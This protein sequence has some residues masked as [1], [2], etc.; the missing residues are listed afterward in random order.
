MIRRLAILLLTWASA[1]PAAGPPPNILFIYSDDQAAWTIGAYGNAQASTPNFDRLASEGARFTQAFAVTPVCSPARAEVM[2]S[3]YGSEVGI[4]DFL[5]HSGHGKIKYDSEAGLATR[6]P[7]FP[8]ILRD[9]GYQTALA[10]KWHLGDT[11]AFHPRQHG[12]DW[13]TGFRDGR[14]P[15]TNPELE[16]DGKLEQSDGFT[17]E[18][19][20]EHALRF[21]QERHPDRPFFLA[22][23]YRAPHSPWKPV[24]PQDE[25]PYRDREM[26]LP[27][28]QHPGLD[29]KKVKSMMAEYLASVSSID[30]NTGRLL[31]ALEQLGL[32]HNTV[33]ILTSDHGYNMGHNGIWHKGNGIWATRKL[34]LQ[35]P[36]I[37]RKYRPNLYDESMRVPLLVRWPGVVKPGT[38]IERVVTN[39]DWFPTLVSMSRLPPPEGALLRGRDFTPLL[40]GEDVPWND[41][42]Y[43]EYSMVNYGIADMRCLRTANW[44][45]VVDFHNRS[46]DELYN[47]LEDP[48]EGRNLIEETTPEIVDTRKKLLRRLHQCRQAVTAG[49]PIPPGS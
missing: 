3:R 1:L 20:T 17:D 44:K 21:L 23:H 37:E 28:P 38:V 40:L 15:V 2:S 35:Q 45:L 29:R 33:V 18:L 46:R 11:D 41:E 26:T 7:T 13:F 30:R 8:R 36:D 49:L 27:Q 9:G 47:L 34:P 4:L 22:V 16:I 32:A 14:L 42:L 12:F 24:L 6:F 19:L 48:A 31:N 43:G 39:L 25:A 5:A 10:G